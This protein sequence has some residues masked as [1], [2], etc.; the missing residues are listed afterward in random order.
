M[1]AHNPCSQVNMP[2]PSLPTV[3][4]CNSQG[5]ELTVQVVEWQRNCIYGRTVCAIVEVDGPRR[6]GESAS[7]S[8]AGTGGQHE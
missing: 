7:P 8:Q 4:K 1:L 3:F 2:E 6:E 5:W